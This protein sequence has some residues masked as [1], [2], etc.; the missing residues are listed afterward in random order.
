[1]TN[2]SC[3]AVF[4]SISGDKVVY[5]SDRNN[6]CDLNNYDL[7]IYDLSTGLERRLTTS[8]AYIDATEIFSN[9]IVYE[10]YSGANRD[11]YLFDLD[12]N[13]TTS[14]AVDF[15][16]DDAWP[17]ISG[18]KIVW[19]HSQGD[20]HEIYL[21]DLST[22]T[23]R[24]ISNNSALQNYPRVS[25][26]KIVWGD[27]RAGSSNVDV[28]MFDL[29]TNSTT[30]ITFD[31][32]YQYRAD[33]S[34]DRIVWVDE[35]GGVN[36]KDIYIYDPPS[37]QP[38][39]PPTPPPP[40]A[41]IKAN[42]SDGPITIAYNTAATISWTSSNATSCS[43]SPTG[44]SGT[45]SGGV[46]TGNLTSS[47]TYTL[48]C[49]G[50]GGTKTDSV[51]VSVSNFKKVEIC[52]WTV[53]GKY[54]VII[55]AEQAALNG[56][57]AH[58][59]DII[60]ATEGCKPPTIKEVVLPNVLTRKNSST[61][62]LSKIADPSKVENFTLDTLV[63]T[64]KFKEP[65]DLSSTE[66]LNKLNFLDLYLK[67]DKLGLISLDSKAL[68]VLNKK[69]TLTMKK[70]PFLKTPR[71]LVDG[72]ED[73]KVVSNIKFSE[74]VLS[75]DISH[76]STITAAPTVAIN[77]PKANFKTSDT[78][79]TLKGS[80]S[81]PTAT[82]SAKLNS[83]DLGS[84][85]VATESGNFTKQIDIAKGLN[86]ISVFAIAGN[87]ATASATVSGTLIEKAGLSL[88]LLLIILLI[89]A[90]S[91]GAAYFAVKRLKKN[92]SQPKKTTT[93]N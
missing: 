34:G 32:A 5:A 92:P 88:A 71:V 6:A 59:G 66:I 73:K 1:L 13:I 64:I 46:S 17:H 87:G 27:Y 42:G 16:A 86:K 11:A 37:T 63:N 14:I 39:S 26:N 49:S 72:K 80:V 7:Y 23:T 68:L 29:A 36:N 58:P 35:R 41:D 53:A 57:L 79:I 43:V 22:N 28:Y 44:W 56:H 65:V 69:A 93:S 90:T 83:K 15:W 89:L 20:N 2:E 3:H 50:T 9:K 12:T 4:P 38:P 52:H 30:Q 8:P 77:E 74:G 91:F 19:G 54:E 40:T 60:P 10:V 82:V 62:N 51:Q 25:G 78:K 48:T 81:D 85:K 67:A 18:D 76:F 31:L 47:K 70:L 45:S 21:N 55:V 75:F 24:N 84:L 61:T 33:I